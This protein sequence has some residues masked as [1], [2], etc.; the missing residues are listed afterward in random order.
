DNAI[1]R[2]LRGGRRAVDI[3]LRA[4]DVL[5]ESADRFAREPSLQAQDHEE[6]AATA[7]AYGLLLH[8]YLM[9]FGSLNDRERFVL[10]MVEVRRMRYGELAVSLGI[11]P[12]A[13]KMVVF[14]ARKRVH[15]RIGELLRASWRSGCE[16]A[17]A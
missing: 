17:V 7:S 3:T 13:L 8:C 15:D 5:Q 1:R 9:A 11:R 6:C 4:P 12:E 2:Q 14:R 16:F 10:Q